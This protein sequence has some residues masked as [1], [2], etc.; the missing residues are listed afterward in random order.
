[1]ESSALLFVILGMLS[2]P[3]YTYALWRVYGKKVGIVG[4]AIY[5]CIVFGTFTLVQVWNM[6]LPLASRL[7]IC[8]FDI[9][10]I[11]AT[12]LI[13]AWLADEWQ[14]PFDEQRKQR[15]VPQVSSPPVCNDSVIDITQPM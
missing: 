13:W 8:F 7:T 5:F 9:V 14:L 6:E 10:G 11:L 3:A 2:I 1:M 15:Q 12:A 4:G